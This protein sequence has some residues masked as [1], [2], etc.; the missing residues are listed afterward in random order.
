MFALFDCNNFYAL[1]KRMFKPQLNCKP[2]VNNGCVV[3][4]SNESKAL[5]IKMGVPLFEVK[6]L[7]Q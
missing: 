4:C 3:E 2:I 5:E 1:C 6:D 7:V